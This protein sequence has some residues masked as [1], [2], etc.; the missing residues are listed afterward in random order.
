M[1]V[2][3]R[4]VFRSAIL[5]FPFFFASVARAEG[6]KYAFLV[7]VGKYPEGSGFASL[8][9]S[10]RDVEQL[11]RVLVASG[12]DRSLVRVLTLGRGG[13]DP[14]YLPNLK[15]IRREIVAL[16]QKCKP[17]D[18]IL[19]AFSG[20]GLTRRV[21]GNGPDASKTRA[22][23]C[24]V[25]GDLA[26]TA[27]LLPLDAVYSCLERSPA[28]A[29][30]LL[31]DACRNDPTEGRAAVIQFQATPPPP[32]VA[33]L[34]SC[35]DNEI[36][37]DADD[38]GGGHGVFFHFVIEGLKGDA[39]QLAGNR[40]GVVNLVELVAYTQD[41][42]PEYV[43]AR[44]G[45]RQMPVLQ[46]NTGRLNLLDARRVAAPPAIV[47]SA[48]QIRLL[49]IPSGSFLM[50]APDYDQGSPPDAKPQH[51]VRITRGFFLGESEITQAQY[52]TVM[53]V[54]PSW[55]TSTGQLSKLLDYNEK[56]TST[57]PVENVSWLD[58]VRFCNELSR[59]E[60]LPLYY[61]IPDKPS[62]AETINSIQ[63]PSRFANGYRLP[64]EAEWEYACRAGTTT[65]YSCGDALAQ[66]EEYG[67]Y[68]DVSG[69]R[70]WDADAYW[71]EQKGD[72]EQ[73]ILKGVDNR[74][75]THPTRS[76]R[77][78]AFGLFD[79][80]GNV[81]EWCADVYT[82]Y[83]RERQE[84][85]LALEAPSKLVRV[86]RGGSAYSPD[87]VLASCCRAPCSADSKIPYIGFRIARNSGN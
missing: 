75:H 60:G 63:I 12:Y 58:A 4:W 20:H 23:F 65:R 2:S 48:G 10:E 70:R 22:Y 61:D 38:L 44:R 73:V 34:F 55:T 72:L 80:H 40:D 14:R 33:A 66:L 29:R 27:S 56:D 30:I 67:W 46:G 50:G 17:E 15:N 37:W 86:L 11:A 77:P 3:R 51:E 42:V 84:D 47:T 45:R 83:T 8:P 28:G 57:F 19:V 71:R 24:P 78:N 64:T 7:G 32:S 26:D 6:E 79:M 16:A 5:T 59:Q 68:A 49:R 18:S 74:C 69:R 21:G 25:D 53:G 43:A 87:L 81:F 41:K 54:N 35:S 39:D 1:T 9:F 82:R 13:D 62:D 85:P 52:Q 36:A 31:V 76:V